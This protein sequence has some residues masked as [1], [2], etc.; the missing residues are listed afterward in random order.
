MCPI[1]P[2]QDLNGCIIWL[3]RNIRYLKAMVQANWP[4]FCSFDPAAAHEEIVALLKGLF[5]VFTEDLHIK[6]SLTRLQRQ[7]K[8]KIIGIS[9]YPRTTVTSGFFGNGG[10]VQS[11]Y[12]RSP[13]LFWS[14]HAGT[15]PYSM[16][17]S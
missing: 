6:S 16:P 7:C 12:P 3:Y 13:K 4:T 5:F 9:L 1:S 2:T 11:P 17:S 15:S 10:Y 8:S 14:S